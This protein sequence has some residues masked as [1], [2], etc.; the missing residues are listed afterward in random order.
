MNFLRSSR[1]T[2]RNVAAVRAF[3]TSTFIQARAPIGGASTYKVPDFSPYLKEDR[4]EDSN[5]VFSYFMVGT[6]G[7]ISA[8]AARA[9]VQDFLTTM[10]ASKDV[11][12]LAKVEVA[13]GNIPEGKNIIVKW[14]GKPVF[15][16]HRTAA[17]IQEANEVNVASLRDPQT[18]DQRVKTPEWLVMVGIC[19]HLGCVPIGESGDYGGWFCPCHGSHYDISGRIRRG[20]APLNLE[21][22]DY[23]FIENN[24]KVVIG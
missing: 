13:L 21:I 4:N 3:G 24:E 7:V 1:L 2:V 19:T 10:S 20:P 12:A 18:D 8:A 14:R 15:I 11:L 16:R 17:E 23:E 5:R 9:T 6:F 22:P